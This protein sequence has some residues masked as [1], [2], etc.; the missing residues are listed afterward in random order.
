MKKVVLIFLVCFCCIGFIQAQLLY[1]I[2]KKGT[3]KSSYLFGTHHLVPISNLKEVD[4]VFRAYN[5]CD[6]VVGEFVFDENEVLKQMT[7]AATMSEKI[8]NLLSKEDYDYVDSVLQADMKLTLSQVSMMRPAMIQY[9]YELTLYEYI[10]PNKEDDSSMDS[11]F[12]RAALMEGKVNKGLESINDQV[13]LLFYMQSLERQAELLVTSLK[14]ELM[15]KEEYETINQLYLD[16][17]IDKLYN[18]L[19]Q[20]PYST[21]N[22]GELFMINDERNLDWIDNLCK[23]IDDSRCFIAVGALHLPGENGLI[24]L[25]KE[26]GY[27]VKPVKK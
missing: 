24:K 7:N 10:F 13:K 1:E 5:D 16:G 2:T 21:L 23:Y 20:P 6:V 14:S 11:F 4:G 15:I 18:T 3:K 12:Q 19:T 9:M 25:L 17:D 8:D 22:E 26:R 27:K